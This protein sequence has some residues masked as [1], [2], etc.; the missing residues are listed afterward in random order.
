[1]AEAT[2]EA[3]K[4]GY[5]I[6]KDR[7]RKHAQQGLARQ[8]AAMVQ[9][10][11]ATES[12][13][14][15]RQE[16]LQQGRKVCEEVAAWRLGAKE[17]NDQWMQHGKSIKESQKES[18]PVVESMSQLTDNKKKQAQAT[19]TEDSAKETEREQLKKEHER[20]V[21]TLAEQVRKETS[22]AVT[23]GAKRV[24]YEQRRAAAESTKSHAS[25]LDTARK[26]NSTRFKEEQNKKRN[27]V[28]EAR[29]KAAESRAQLLSS[30]AA[31]AASVR[32]SSKG[33]QEAHKT[34]MQEEY[35][36]KAATV[37]A[38]VDNKVYQDP[39]SQQASPKQLESPQATS[40]GSRNSS[41]A[42]VRR[43]GY[44]EDDP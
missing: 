1:M 2:R 35:M 12:T 31:D 21:K 44:A 28:R 30:R 25:K 7:Q 33:Y 22:D 29:V 10:K 14:A 8:Q 42:Q 38:V 16:N 26:D 9:M 41:P 40:T 20:Q 24:F 17:K 36:K 6:I 4:E 5:D 32:D 13:E 43:S 27:T 39:A 19:R 11:R 18:S 37:K 3:A 34:R 15:H 23:D